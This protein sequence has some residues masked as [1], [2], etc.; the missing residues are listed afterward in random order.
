[1]QN[2]PVRTELGR[3]LRKM[4][5]ADDGCVL[6]D[7]DYSQIELR[8]LAHIADD[9]VMK[10]AFNEDADIHSATAM[11][12]FN[13]DKE[14]LTSEMRSRAKTVNFGIVYGMG[15]FSL[16]KDLKIPVFEA[17]KYIAN[18][19]ERFSGVKR[20]LDNIVEQAKEDGYVSTM[21]NRR[22]YLPEL[23]ANNFI[24]RSFGERVAMNTPIQGSAADIIK[25]A[26]V[27]V[28]N[29]LKA[30]KLKSKLVLQVHD[31][32]I[33]EAYLDEAEQVKNILRTEMENAYKMNVPLKVDMN[34]GVTWYDAK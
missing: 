27:K 18:Y 17:R 24:T 6:A 11:Q 9:E 7:A 16:A 29:R 32:L 21:L 22:R 25:L 10:K 31:E 34:T 3:E 13:V 8:V 30:E 19:F 33:I 14:N 15:E 28:Y 12:I 1:L 2:I 4:F 26:M 20:Y 5:V 23:S